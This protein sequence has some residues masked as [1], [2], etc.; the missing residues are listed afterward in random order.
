MKEGWWINYRT[1]MTV[2]IGIF[3]DHEMW[4]RE[5]GNAAKLGVPGEVIA[6]FDGFTPGQER[7]HFLTFVMESASVMRVRGHG[8]YVTFEYWA[9]NDRD[10][11]RAIRRFTTGKL[12]PAMGMNVVN[13]RCIREG[14]VA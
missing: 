6:R 12:G 2:C 5:P 10:A 3:G 9:K 4:L 14:I 11:L 1:G 7:L 13:L 8:H